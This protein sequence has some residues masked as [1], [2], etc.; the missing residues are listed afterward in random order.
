LL[1]RAIKENGSYR[2]VGRFYRLLLFDRTS[3]TLHLARNVGGLYVNRDH[4][5]DPNGRPPIQVVDAKTQRESVEFICK[6]MFDPDNFKIPAETYNQFGEEKWLS[7]DYRIYG[8]RTY[9]FRDLITMIQSYALEELIGPW[10]LESLEDTAFRVPESEDV[11][12]PDELFNMLT[13]A[14]FRELDTV[15]EGEFTSRKPAVIAVRRALQE[16]YF[17]ILSQYTLGQTH[18]TSETSQSLARQQLTSLSSNIQAVL[19]GKG[20]LDTLSR[21]HLQ[22]LLDRIKKVL[23]ADIVRRMP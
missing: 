15:K 17:E 13:G 21:S 7:S 16:Y 12:T 8:S 14:I 20:K 11:F 1:D 4:R 3:A 2:D 5:G 22:T 9:T 6:N 18:S 10:V 23:D 19:S